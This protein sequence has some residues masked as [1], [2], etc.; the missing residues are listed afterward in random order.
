M[1]RTTRL[2]GKIK[3]SAAQEALLR[4]RLRGE[5]AAV[6]AAPRLARRSNRSL[7]PLSLAQEGQWLLQQLFPDSALLN[8]FAA[9][10]SSRPINREALELALTEVVRRHDIMRTNF[11]VIDGAPMQIVS[12]PEPVSVDEH[13]FTDLPVEDRRPALLL[14]LRKR[15][16]EPFDLSRDRLF[17]FDVVRLSDHEQIVLFTLHHIIC[18]AWSLGILARE[19][20][21]F[22]RAI[23]KGASPKG[24]E[25]PIQ[26][27]DYATWQRTT[28]K[29]DAIAKQLSFWRRRLADPPD[30][31]DLPFDRTPP[32]VRS[33]R[34]AQRSVA[35][36]PALVAQLRLLCKREHTTLFM[37]MIAA[38]AALIH[39]YSGA[40]DVV[41]GSPVANRGISE[42]EPLVGLFMNTV[43]F[44]FDLSG[45]PPFREFLER[46]RA[47][48]LEIFSNLAVAFET[49]VNE[50]GLPHHK[51]RSPLFQVMFVMQ[52][53]RAASIFAEFGIDASE[54]TQRGSKFDL[55][56]TF[57][58]NED[59]EVAGHIEY[60]TDLFDLVTVDRMFGHLV[61]LLAQIVADPRRRISAMTLLDADERRRTLAGWGTAP[62]P[63]PD[64][65]LHE[66]F[67]V[68][69]A[70]TPDAVAVRDGGETIDYRTLDGRAN[71]F[72]WRLR[73]LGV[74]PDGIVGIYMRRSAGLIVA[75]LGVLKAGGAYLPLDP[76]YPPDRIAA[77]L[78]DAKP[79]VV[80]AAPGPAASPPAGP[81]PVVTLDG[82]AAGLDPARD[83]PP[84]SRT[85]PD[86]LAY[87]L[88]TSGSTGRPKG[89]MGTHRAVVNRLNWD[90]P[91]PSGHEIY[92]QKTTLGFIDALWE[93]FMPLI[94]GGSTVIVPEEAIRDPVRM[95]DQLSQEGTTRLV[96]VPSLLRSILGCSRDL[97]SALPNLRH[98]ACSGEALPEHLAAQFEARLPGAELFN[99]Y[100]TSE[101]WDATWR[102]SRDREPTPTVGIGSPIAN[103]RAV[104]LDE[105]GEPAPANVAG[106]LFVS[107]VGL[108]R[109]YLGQPGLT[110]ERFLPDPFGDG[111]RIYR[112]GDVA[113]RRA[114]G[115]L[116]LLGRRDNQ[117]KLRGHR[118]ELAEIEQA[119]LDCPGVRHAVV[120]LR[121]DLP[122][123]EAG[124]VAYL[125]PRDLVLSD[126][127]LRR[128][129][130]ARLPAQMIPA[131]FVALAQFPMLPNGKVDL[132]AL[133]RPEPKQERS[134][135]RAPPKTD[136]ELALTDIWKDVLGVDEVDTESNFFELGGSSMSLVRVQNGIRERLRRD[137]TVIVL[138]RYPTIRAL[139]SFLEDGRQDDVIVGS[140]KRGEARKRFLARRV[141]FPTRLSE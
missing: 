8:T 53:P 122:S 120:R 37:V 74:G 26:Y 99:I 110:A 58:E 20:G 62:A 140:T 100:G 54:V 38:L 106:E 136:L 19:T 94:R 80:V 118:I 63:Y 31:T 126:A 116:E 24:R 60:A 11:R 42:T 95:V 104:V 78:A 49:V 23:E 135:M 57:S 52:P 61:T 2:S 30:Q 71:R 81:A 51:D 93:I 13:D 117:V 76:D 66:L 92:A 86:N 34:G 12:P 107:G 70:R 68:Q 64:A 41:I 44:R 18:D 22:Y 130:E 121:D 111:E 102:S 32:P 97:A 65:C 132:A 59:G 139:R 133:P 7:A 85:W 105:D 69:A 9:E 28:L 141:K 1:R 36:A 67:A 77:M 33:F 21:A 89:V 91:R 4:K 27:G 17:R 138:F 10:R 129:L 123:Q 40:T 43:A 73:D 25:L 48:T 109:G 56:L 101:F 114:D 55:T 47:D 50:L 98:W 35:L 108:A 15:T 14:W 84:A 82:D 127:A 119:L 39:R 115:G 103:M 125:A 88:Y 90:V 112:T 3:L 72:A 87:V 96:L 6:S 83:A 79:I 128:R 124:L 75:L 29:G 134:R 131:H 46:V 16:A 137:V 45:D 5:G 113:R